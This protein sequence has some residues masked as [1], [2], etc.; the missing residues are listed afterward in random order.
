MCP[1][2]ENDS[3]RYHPINATKYDTTTT[4]DST[5]KDSTIGSY[6]MCRLNDT[7]S[8]VKDIWYTHGLQRIAEGKV[9]VLC[10]AGGQGSRLGFEKPKG[11]YPIGALSGMSLFQIF[12]ER[13]R[14]IQFLASGKSSTP[15][16]IP[17]L[18]MTSNLNHD[19]TRQLFEVNKYFDLS[20]QQVHLF[21]Q[22][23]FPALS[24]EG[25]ILMESKGKVAFGGAGNG[26]I[27][28]AI[29]DTGMDKLL[30]SLGVEFVHVVGVDNALCMV[31]DPVFVGFASDTGAEVANKCVE[32]RS[33]TE[34][35]GVV[36]LKSVGGGTVSPCVVEYSELPEKLRDERSS[37]GSLQY[38]AGNICNH[39]FTLNFIS[40]IIDNAHLMPVHRADKKIACIDM[41][42]GEKYTPTTPNGI[43]PE[44][45]I[46]DSFQFT[47]SCHVLLVDRHEE[48]APLK[49]ATGEDSP[50]T[51]RAQMSQIST[52]RLKS[53][54]W[55]IKNGEGGACEI[56]PLIAYRDEGLEKDAREVSLPFYLKPQ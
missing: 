50:E 52:N 53:A 45:F 48:F 29:R 56:S 7:H 20:P 6:S 17:F 10:M 1:T 34:N 30:M 40:R 39:L 25:D 11:M 24:F 12:A 47:A 3:P 14:R 9:A 15:V 44:L 5:T 32:K 23:D 8:D 31:C 43:K 28:I 41:S 19:D 49:N 55:T 22:S 4:K 37:D 33:P 35:V 18:V 13:I 42:T 54:G 36:C 51:V 21:K 26:A 46:F 38:T 27:F 16:V 2:K